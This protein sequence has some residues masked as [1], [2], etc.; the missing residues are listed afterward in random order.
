MEV[1]AAHRVL[2]P[3]GIKASRKL[4]SKWSQK[5]LERLGNKDD[6]CLS[7]YDCRR[8][9]LSGKLRQSAN[10][11]AE[12]HFGEWRKCCSFHDPGRDFCN[13]RLDIRNGRPGMREFE[14]GC[15]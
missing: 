3:S 12:Q 13:A 10:G 15:R 14:Y 4:F 5:L 9:N 8:I 2:G 1:K 11:F 7:A 6:E